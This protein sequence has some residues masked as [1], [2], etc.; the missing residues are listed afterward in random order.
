[1]KSAIIVAA[2]KSARFGEDKLTALLFDK[3]VL[4]YSVNLFSQLCDEVILVTNEEADYGKKVKLAKGGATRFESVKNGLALL[5]KESTLVAIHDGARPFTSKALAEKLF[6][7]AE[8]DGSAIPYTYVADTAYYDDKPLL[9]EHL[10]LLQTPQI[11]ETEKIVAAYENCRDN[12]SSDDSQVYRLQYGKVSFVLGEKSNAKITFRDD[13][14]KYRIGYGFDVHS[15]TEGDGVRLG[16]ITIPF[17]KKLLGHSDADA[18]IHSIM[19]ALLSACGEKD[20]GVIFPN[21]D[22]SLK[23]IDSRVLLKRVLDI[24]DKKGCEVLG[25]SSV[26]IAEA[27]KIAPHVDAMRKELSDILSLP[28]DCVNVSATT[29]EGLGIVGDGK[30]IAAQSMALCAYKD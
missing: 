14:P 10:K 23:G 5:D 8:K 28:F 9:R 30:G 21:S 29:T 12:T 2:G 1:M 11:F 20:I 27:P 7:V 25:V 26:I 17:N 4:S 15:L 22:E 3:T 13:L 18:L 24:L 19:D 16:G 6:S